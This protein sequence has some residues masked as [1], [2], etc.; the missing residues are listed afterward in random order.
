MEEVL[1]PV[2]PA[3]AAQGVEVTAEARERPVAV[4]HR[5]AETLAWLRS[6]RVELD[7]VTWP[8]RDE[9]LKATRMIVAL[10]I[11]L[12][13]VIGVMDWLLNLILVGGVAALTR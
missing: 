6:A 5:A 1:P 12:G 8:T 9:L 13:V 2:Q 10:S 4:T 11:L 7:K 3:R